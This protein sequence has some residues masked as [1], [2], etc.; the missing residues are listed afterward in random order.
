MRCQA[1]SGAT[2]QELHGANRTGAGL[3][4]AWVLAGQ[5]ASQPQARAATG[6]L[7]HG[8]RGKATAPTGAKHL[9]AAGANMN[10]SSPRTAGCTLQAHQTAT[11][12]A[13]AS[14]I[15]TNIP[16]LIARSIGAAIAGNTM[17][18]IR[19]RRQ[20]AGGGATPGADGAPI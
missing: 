15:Q 12:T 14:G 7:T 18:I 3:N 17:Q 5:H 11:A 19:A 16:S 9:A 2:A 6:L 8:A 4:I 20:A 10:H 1:A 13:A